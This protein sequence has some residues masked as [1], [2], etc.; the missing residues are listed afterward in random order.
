MNYTEFILDKITQR[1]AR[2]KNEV[3]SEGK[4]FHWTLVRA[5]REKEDWVEM[6]FPDFQI[7]Y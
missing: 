3:A 6:Q 1:W 5:A 2:S 4:W 7:F